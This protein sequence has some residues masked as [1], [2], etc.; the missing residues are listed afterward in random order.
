M[1]AR[2]DYA[3]LSDPGRVRSSNQDSWFADPNQGLFIVS[4]GMGGHAAG[5]VASKIVVKTLPPLLRQRLTGVRRLDEP[6]AGRRLMT[7]I[8]DLSAEVRAAS[9]HKPGLSGMGATVVLAMIKNGLAL[10]GH[11][12]DSRAYLYRRGRLNQLTRDHSIIQ[13]LVD[14][15]QISAEEAAVHPAKG[16][17]TR[18]VGMDGEV[19]PETTSLNLE[20]GDR[21]LLCC[22]GL[23]DMVPDSKISHMMDVRN[24]LKDSCRK[25]VDAANFAGGKDNITVVLVEWMGKN[26]G[27]SQ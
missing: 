1:T 4:D 9:L 21:L 13:I 11:L 6:E 19:L 18:A 2:L 25:L 27:G 26:T 23:T 3:G 16:Q 20:P 12:G 10:I 7:S 8:S 14:T 15:G 24:R 5:E 17:I 22:D